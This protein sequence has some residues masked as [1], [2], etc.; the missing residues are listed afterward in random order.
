MKFNELVSGAGCIAMMAWGMCALASELPQ[1]AHTFMAAHCMDC[2]DADTRKGGLDLSTLKFDLADARTFNQWIKIHDRVRDGEMPPAKAQ[3]RPAPAAARVF[4]D[5][6]ATPMIAADDERAASY[7]RSVWRRLNRLEYE[8]AVRDL[9]E[10]PWLQIKERLPEDREAHRFNKDG[11]ALS[12]SHIQMA[13]Y[14]DAARYALREVEA[15][16]AQAPPTINKRFY[17]REQP[18]LGNKT[19]LPGK[20]GQP[21]KRLVGGR[22]A[23]AILGTQSDTTAYDEHRLTVGAADPARRDEEAVGVVASSYEA[24]YLRYDGFRAK[25]S[26]RYKLR[27]CALSFW[28]GPNDAK[29]PYW[30]A[31]R[32]KISR[33]RVIEPVTLYG[34]SPPQTLRWLGT[35][36]AGPDPSVHELEVDLLAGE[37]ICPDPARLYRDRPP[38]YHNALATKTDGM[39]GVAF[40]WMEVEGPILTAWPSKGHTTL[41]GDLPIQDAS[42]PDAVAE[43]QPR[44]APNDARRLLTSFLAKAYRRPVAAG[45]IE[46]FIAVYDGSRRLGDTFMGAMNSAYSAILCSPG[47]VTVEERPGKLD[48]FALATR[49][50][51]FLW[52]TTPD[53]TLRDLAENGQLHEPAIL[54]QQTSRLLA[55]P[56][57]RRFINAFL[58]YWLDL[59]K[60]DVS[61]PDASLYPDYYLDDLLVE[62]AALE[63]QAFFSELLEKNLPASNLVASDF[64]MLNSRL[65]T[66]YG[67]PG[68]T[69]VAIRRVALPPDSPR[70]GLLTQA[71]V[72]KVTANGTTTSPVVRGAWIMERILGK[73]PSPPPPNVPAVDPDIRGAKTIREQLQ[74]HRTQP[75]CAACHARIDP[76]GFALEMFDVVGGQRAF[77]RSVGEGKPVEGYGHDGN[78]FT[79]HFGPPVDASGE[80]PDGRHFN[81]IREFK[82]LLLA[83][84]RGIAHN[85]VDQL[86]TYATGAAVRFGDRPQVEAILGRAA[87]SRFG[88]RSLIEELVQSDLFQSK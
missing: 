45:E 42:S 4:L 38:N 2:H 7:G 85:L 63:T 61:S 33:G 35:V 23:L 10:T 48:D 15:A 87:K 25:V 34:D 50:S 51:L 68:V 19:G 76:A 18:G 71:S 58:D 55:D 28:E 53:Q 52:N 60:L 78:K 21:L 49:L 36:D 3:Q 72:L 5:A 57:A 65:A 29:D 81:D 73:P 30:V 84:E 6:L 64:A 82:T 22:G 62:S 69:G 14:L 66:H 41:F 75:S 46:R 16:Q 74:K 56:R 47:F 31:D 59:R 20:P 86:V 88:V 83:D 9:L 80:L 44:D 26:G 40:R 8:N 12:V 24:F 70:G 39:P 1:P 32:T 54:R 67:I 77:Y 13:G 11:L 43:V 17:A 37:T 79:W 27:F